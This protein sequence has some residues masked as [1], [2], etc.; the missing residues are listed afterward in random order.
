MQDKRT[1]RELIACQRPG[2]SLEQRFYSDPEIYRLEVDH[3][4]MEC[5]N[6]PEDELAVF[7]D[8]DARIDI[9][10][11]DELGQLAYRVYQYP[12]LIRSQDTRDNQV[13][14]RLEQ[15]RIASLPARSPLSTVWHVDRSRC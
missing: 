15:V 9:R 1:I 13:Q 3:I 14:A 6:R 4:V 10:S 5:R 2:W 7:R 8:L 12:G 11:R